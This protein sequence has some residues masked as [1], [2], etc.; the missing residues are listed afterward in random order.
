MLGRQK[1][2]RPQELNEPWSPV[3]FTVSKM[4]Q[5]SMTCPPQQPSPMLMPARGMS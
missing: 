5:N 4:S 3:S 1:R 2:S